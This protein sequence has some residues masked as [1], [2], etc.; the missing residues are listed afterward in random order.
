MIEENWEKI[1]LKNIN[2]DI[3]CLFSLFLFLS[4]QTSELSYI[5]GQ[6]SR[7]F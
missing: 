6:H 4:V 1:N 3:F 2:T 5:N 7:T